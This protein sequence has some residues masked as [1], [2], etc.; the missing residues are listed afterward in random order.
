[1]E[2]AQAGFV[3][4]L[5]V[6]LQA[7]EGRVDQLQQEN[8]MLHTELAVSLNLDEHL[9]TFSDGYMLRSDCSDSEPY[10]MDCPNDYQILPLDTL[11]EAATAFFGVKTFC[12]AYGPESVVIG[13]EGARTTV[14][15]MMDQLRAWWIKWAKWQDHAEDMLDDTFGWERKTIDG[16][17]VLIPRML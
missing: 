4:M 8:T 6:R 3:T 10:Q 15:E 12:P 2:T 5:M 14:K 11:H 13:K 17:A 16:K 1:M 7:L 9:C